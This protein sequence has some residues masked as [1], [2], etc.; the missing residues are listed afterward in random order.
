MNA[1]PGPARRERFRSILFPDGRDLPGDEARAEPECFR[2]LA[3]GRVVESM[4]A[5]RQEYDLV[6]FFHLPLR[7]PDAVLHRQEVMRDLER[8][9]V[10]QA[11]QAFAERMRSARR[12]LDSASRSS[13]ALERQRW[14]LAAAE[15]YVDALAGLEQEL[16]VLDLS[17][18][19][20][21]EF[22]ADL[23]LRVR[24]EEF[25]ALRDEARAVVAALAAIRYGLLIRGGTVTLLP[26][27]GGGDYGA[28]I[29]ETFRKFRRG[30]VRDYRY[31]F[32]DAPGL[33]HVEAELLERVALRNPDAFAALSRFCE[34]HADFVD[35]VYSRFDREIQFYAAWLDWAA[36]LR[37]AGA[38]FC[39]PDVSRRRM[40]VVVRDSCDPALAESLSREGR[41]VVLN[42]VRLE[43]GERVLVV[44]GPNQGGKTT[45]ARAF[46]QL[47][48]LASLGGPVP[49]AEARLFLPDRLLTHFE[50]E[51]D[52]VN[53]RGKLEDDLVRIRRLLLEATPDSILI[54]NEIFSSTTLED[55]LFLGRAVLERILRLDVPCVFVTF[56]D[57]LAAGGGKTVSV[58]SGVDPLDPERRTF[59][60]ERRPA[61]GLAHALAIA[62]KHRV[63]YRRLAERLGA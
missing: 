57:E 1:E 13:Y 42:D 12:C 53:L 22:R 58:A 41:P 17:S 46:G 16:G 51:E 44:T 50:R 4:A 15:A 24:S 48:Y 31:R 61:D 3:L 30:P 6:P 20:L 28:V 33:N 25:L 10:R 62:E 27:D 63:T 11:L 47:H 5:G 29:E 21:D 39:Y 49:A 9:P 26:D 7:D 45:F 8:R 19:G 52:L 38:P 55:A 34:G 2:D 23:G 18:R 37:A 40:D 60:F 36:R 43:G 54:L 14:Q 56:L 59:R 35:P 32:A